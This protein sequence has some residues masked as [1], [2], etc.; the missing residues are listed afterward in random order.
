MSAS[1]RIR[2]GLISPI[3][4]AARR[5]IRLLGHHRRRPLG[6]QGKGLEVFKVS[7]DDWNRDMRMPM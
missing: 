3:I 7:P 1:L 4:V 6:L 5:S 2:R